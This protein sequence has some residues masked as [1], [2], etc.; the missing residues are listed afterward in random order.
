VEVYILDDEGK[1]LR[2]LRAP[3]GVIEIKGAE[4]TLILT[5]SYGGTRQGEDVQP[6]GNQSTITLGPFDLRQPS[7][8]PPSLDLSDMT[9]RQLMEKRRELEKMGIQDMTPVL[10]QLHRQVAFSFACIGFTLIGIPLGIQAHRRETTAGVAI[11][12]VLVMIYYSFIILSQSLVTHPEFGPHLIVWLP[13]FVF[14]VSGG[15]LLWKANRGL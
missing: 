2:W 12:L 1:S 6:A 15:Y 9:F 7:D 10:I 14:Q 4:G 3:T 5:N 13:N 11:A 8:R